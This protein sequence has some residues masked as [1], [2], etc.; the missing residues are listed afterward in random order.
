M[1]DTGVGIDPAFLPHI[2]DRFS[3]EDPGQ[4]RTHGGLGLGLTIVRHLVE[5]H[6]GTVQAV[7]AGKGKGSTFTVLLPL[8]QKTEERPA[9]EQAPPREGAGSIEG[10]RILVVDDDSATREALVEV[11]SLD[12]AVVR[13]AESPAAAM[14][15]FTEFRPELLV[16]DIAMPGEDGYGLIA[17]VRALGPERGGDVPAL[18]LTALATTDDR[19]RALEAGFQ[20]HMGK[21]VDVDRLVGTLATL[22]RPHRRAGSTR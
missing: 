9:G 6:G 21:P 8:M 20:A 22:L 10:A 18:A 1:S 5:A 16:S 7:S 17:R 14:K 12:G 2:F 3:Q 13:S 19:Q 11:L 15:A 4:T